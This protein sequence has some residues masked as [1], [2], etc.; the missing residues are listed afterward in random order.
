M[1]NCDWEDV[2][3]AVVKADGSFAGVPCASYEEARDLA[4]QHEGAKIFFLAYEPDED[5]QEENFDDYFPP[6][7]GF[8]PYEGAYTFDC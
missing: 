3:W 4:A 2:R 8:D 5:E 7:T 6:D 1:K